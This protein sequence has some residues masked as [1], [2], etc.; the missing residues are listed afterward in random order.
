MKRSRIDRDLSAF[1][2]RACLREG[3]ESLLAEAGALVA[4]GVEFKLAEAGGGEGGGELGLE[5]G[6]LE[7]WGFFRGDLDEGFFTEVTD[8]DNAEAEAADGLLGLFNGGEAVGG[9]GET[10]GES[11]GEAGGGGFFGDFQAGFAGEGADIRLG[12]AGIAERG[13]DGE[14]TG[15]GAAGSD[16]AGVVKVFPVGE[17]GDA[18]EL[19]Q[20]PHALKKFG[21]AEVAAVGRVGGVGGVVQFQGAEDFDGEGVF[22]GEGEGGGMF[23]AR[24]AGGVAEDAG[25][26]GAEESVGGPEEK[27]GV[28]PA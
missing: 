12:E 25:D 20:L 9:D 10:G 4:D 6:I 18:A 19:G 8:A 15:G 28:D 23:R 14:F 3:A 27:G 11:G 7:A 17:D 26:L 21:A 16:F 22:L 2:E 13:G 24:E 5:F 1:R